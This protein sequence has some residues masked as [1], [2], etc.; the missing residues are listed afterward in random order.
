M[1]WSLQNFKN[2]FVNRTLLLAAS[3]SRISVI[4]FWYSRSHFTLNDPRTNVIVIN[5][6]GIL[7]NKNS[8]ND[9]HR[10]KQCFTQVSTRIRWNT[11][12]ADLFI[13]LHNQ[14]R[15]THSIWNINNEYW[16]L[17][18]IFHQ[19]DI[20][21]MVANFYGKIWLRFCLNTGKRFVFEVSFQSQEKTWILLKN[22][23]MDLQNSLPFE[24]LVYFMW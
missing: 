14:L 10:E 12:L 8:L 24:R 6:S 20:K 5:K 3:Y 17:N 19:I 9:T 1:L 11:R 4:A 23:T 21:W 18:E 15:Y 13:Y 2:T 7:V 16:C 22:G